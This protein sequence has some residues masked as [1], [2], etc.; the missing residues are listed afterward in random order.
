MALTLL[1]VPVLAQPV[2][3]PVHST[4]EPFLGTSPKNN[5]PTL[6]AQFRYVFRVVLRDQNGQPINGWPATRLRLNFANTSNP[7]HPPYA[8]P[9]GQSDALGRVEFSYG[10]TFGGADPG[11]VVI[12]YDPYGSGTSWVALLHTED[13]STNPCGGVRSPDINGDQLVTLSDLAA[14]Q[15]AFVT[16]SP[17]YVG[18]LAQPFDCLIS[19]IDLAW[20]RQHFI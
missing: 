17:A 10:L 3:S 11:S 4:C 5:S 16:Q 2:P 8:P 12:E 13:Y 14:W 20:F 19:L 9:D 1:A 15:Q 7:G 6:P 18:D